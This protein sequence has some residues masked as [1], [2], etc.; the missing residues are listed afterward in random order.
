MRLRCLAGGI[1]GALWALAA[2]AQP[3][4]VSG[5]VG[6]QFPRVGP[7]GYGGNGPGASVAA[8]SLDLN[9]VNGSTFDSRITFTRASVASYFDASGA[10]QSAAVNTP[11]I[12]YDPVTHAV[13]GLLI[14]EGR[15]NLLLNSATLVTQSV[16]TTAIAYTLSFYSTGSVALS[17]SCA[18]NPAGTG[19]FPARVSLTFTATAGT[20][21]VT[22]TGSVLNAQIEAGAFPTSWITTAGASAAR[23]EDIATMA[24]GTWLNAAA[25]SIVAEAYVPSNLGAVLSLTSVDDGSSGNRTIVT[26]TVS[27][28]ATTQTLTGFS[29]TGTVNTANTFTNGTVFKIGT[30]LAGAGGQ[31]TV[32][33]NGGSIASA[34]ISAMPVGITTARFGRNLSGSGIINGYLRRIRYWPR[35][36]SNPELQAVAT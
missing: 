35:A 15:T 25:F 13:R 16:T 3:G 2:A 36:L 27:N 29:G 24:V 32:T 17:G 18:G 11:R 12:D 14:E 22:V 30:A 8:P 21:T 31:A 33:L 20:C 26:T 19:A 9:F 6:M 23:S 5:P 1:V 34:A 28:N 7:G 10:I 4:P